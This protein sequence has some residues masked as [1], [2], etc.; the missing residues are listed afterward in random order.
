[1]TMGRPRLPD[2]IH[3]LRGTL[4]ADRHG[5][6][7][8]K[9]KASSAEPELPDGFGPER[10]KL[11]NGLKRELKPLGMWSSTYAIECEMLVRVYHRMRQLE[12]DVDKNG[13]IQTIPKFNKGGKP[14]TVD[15]NGDNRVIVERK[16]NPA[17]REMAKQTALLK[18]L[19]SSLCLDA[20][21][22]TRLT[23]DILDV[24]D[25]LDAFGETG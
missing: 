16:A 25:E 5:D 13:T 14:L 18:N 7:S 23:V 3:Q 20:S 2:S 17:L 1:M 10:E 12:A 6:P 24:D 21:A 8:T 22:L 11:W 4:R 19:C 15:I 9:V